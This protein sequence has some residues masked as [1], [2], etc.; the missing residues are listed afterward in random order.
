MRG[1]PL[2][3]VAVL[4]AATA[5]V[6]LLWR[7]LGS[8]PATDEPAPVA[9][10]PERPAAPAVIAPASLEASEEVRRAA[11]VSKRAESF[12]A[13]EAAWIEGRVELPPGTPP[14]DTLEVW[15]F[16]HELALGMASSLQNAPELARRGEL[17]KGWWARRP[18]EADGR[19]RV[20]VPKDVGVAS[21]LVDGRFLFGSDSVQVGSG[22]PA[23]LRPQLGA[24]LVGRCTLPANAEAADSPVGA[25]VRV[26]EERTTRVGADLA[27][28]VRGAPPD[29]KSRVVV[30]PARLARER[31]D[32]LR[33][34]AGA[35]REV[36]V[37]L[38]F[39]GRAS[40]RVVDEQ[41]A[42][43]A[44]ASI[45]HQ[46][47]VFSFMG[48]DDLDLELPGSQ[49]LGPRSGPDGSFELFGL[50]PKKR[51]IHA[52]LDG[53]A[54]G[55]SEPFEL[56]DGEVARDI[57]VV[58]SRGHRLAGR[59]SWPDG[60]PA[61]GAKV[62]VRS[63]PDPDEPPRMRF[64]DEHED[65]SA[66]TDKDGA[67]AITGLGGGTATLFA[68]CWPPEHVPGRA[69]GEN[70]PTW[71][72]LLED[73]AADSEGLALVLRAPATLAG[74]VVDEL[75]A[76]VAKF[77]A[78]ARAPDDELGSPRRS[79]L[80]TSTA[81]V[82]DSQDGSFVLNGLQEGR[83][84]VIVEAKGY[85]QSEPQPVVDVPQVG[86]P[87][88]VRVA[89]AGS[90]S[91]V[92]LDPEGE[93]VGE[94]VV[95]ASLRPGG[96][97]FMVENGVLASGTSDAQG[98]FVVEDLPVGSVTL[99]AQKQDRASS[100]PLTI[101]IEPAKRVEGLVLRLRRGG[102]LTG[103]AYDKTGARAAGREIQVF[104]IGSGDHREATTDGAGTFAIES[105]SPGTY[106]VML[107]PTDEEQQ[108]MMEK[109][110][111]GGEFDVAAFFESMKMSSAQIQEGETTHVVL[112][113]P[114]RA[115]VRVFGR[116]TRAGQPVGGG[117]VLCIGEGGPVLS[118]MKMGKV[119]ASGDYEVTLD[120]PGDVQL[121]YQA[122]DGSGSQTD[123]SVTVPEESEFRYDLALPSGGI[124]GVVR[125]TDGRPLAEVSVG[126]RRGGD[127][128][129]N[130]M[131]AD[132]NERSTTDADGRFEFR[133]LAAGTYA[134]AA[135]GGGILFQG[136]AKHGRSLRGGLAVRPDEV[137]EGVE[138]VLAAPCKIAGIVRGAEGRPLPGATVFARDERGLIVDAISTCTTGSDGT[139]EY[140]GVAAGSYTLLART[141]S[142][143]T[144][145][146][147]PVAAREDAP[148]RVE[149]EAVPGTILVVT[150]EDG[151]GKTLRGSVSVRDE[152]GREM[153]GLQ[154]MAAIESLLTEGV[155][156]RVRRI[157]PLAPGEYQVSATMPDG[158]S[159]K[160]TVGLRG[161][162]DRSVKLKVD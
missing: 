24:W 18:V 124:R 122:S 111:E 117:H 21:L 159:A 146:S 80:T 49:D 97:G 7:S 52:S 73:V 55:R 157:G 113:A 106:Q 160:K 95:T 93:P 32:P 15:A 13:A 120:E 44:N 6:F 14:D 110:G 59:V 28:E 85:I 11:D 149:L 118:K 105:L 94:A 30:R 76:P 71:Y 144:P 38:R 108:K 119:T 4:L 127:V 89:R 9:R 162:E 41:G 100:E 39:G 42:G 153:T 56:Q 69:P 102:R 99:V 19:F 125:G 148:A 65:R 156:S 82:T 51:R 128:G 12:P 90:A 155:D 109:A 96:G 57:T 123:F 61:V 1:K 134:V 23:V 86:E 17:E 101:Q 70:Q 150:V 141:E 81:H 116:V 147:A 47:E 26:G 154:G 58:L 136:E 78:H 31:V 112:G 35:K 8:G 20:P 66:T 143:A 50:P 135:G 3:L 126:L 121:G 103:E 140:A 75:G 74:R 132:V 84:A 48:M 98:A 87:L 22:T 72:A 83:W 37:A 2:A 138:I 25:R 145:E 133:G 63:A 62:E 68:T 91:G 10:E 79:F 29:P 161:Q 114:P 60:T 131:S 45:D 67:F 88:V 151:E 53:F 40:G 16:E 92:V 107:Q 104:G 137:L 64:F 129:L 33:L 142:L 5:G 139:F 158:R 130:L 152:R 43:L 27:F 36:E 115:P 46:P 77:D 34:D 54:D